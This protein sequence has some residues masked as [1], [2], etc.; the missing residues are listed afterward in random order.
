MRKIHIINLEK[1]GGVERLFLQYIHDATATD[2]IIFCICNKIG[3]EIAC[4]LRD[5]KIVFVN[6]I[7]NKLP[8]K[9]PSFLRKYILQFRLW[10]TNAQAIIVWDL[11]PCFAGKP[12]R[13]KV[14][15]YDHGCSWRYPH[16]KKTLGFFA[17]VDGCISA[18]KASRRVMELRFDPKFPLQVVINRILAP[19]HSQRG[20]KSPLKPLRLGVAARLVGLKGI[21]VALLTV[22]TLKERGI[23]ATL[24]IAGKG[25]AE[26]KFRQLVRRL[27]ITDRVNF[28]GFRHDLSDFFHRI[29]IYLSTPVTE[30]FGLSCMEAL[31]YGVPV[32]FPLVDGQ[33]E[34]V[35]DGFCGIGVT[36]EVTP[37]AH[38][39]LTG[40]DI[41]FPYHVYSPCQDKLVAPRLIS[42]QAAA[43]AVEKI[44]AS[45]S[46]YQRYRTNAF[47]HAATHFD[48][49]SFVQEFNNKISGIVNA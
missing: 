38:L 27:D 21:S 2:D 25:P 44:V 17:L 36:P 14:I 1:M 16:D 23:D 40:V 15:Y 26:D 11:V 4:H 19:Q 35:R 13:G 49:Q 45:E 32:V 46:E 42:H 20:A 6:R 8:M 33:P 18:A 31:F 7:L 48:Y 24:D 30:P 34:V 39:A 22:K 10:L 41:N 47:A 37:E 9:Y 5:K 29:H 28:L 3:P 12:A 43:D